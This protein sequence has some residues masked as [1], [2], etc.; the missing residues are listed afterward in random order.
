MQ[1]DEKDSGAGKLDATQ[2]DTPA[3]THSE[4]LLSSA[5]SSTTVPTMR[6]NPDLP[7]SNGG[8]EKTI[9]ACPDPSNS[10]HG[11]S[12]PEE[13]DPSGGLHQEEL[14]K[15]RHRSKLQ[16]VVLITIVTTGMI[17]NVSVHLLLFFSSFS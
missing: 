7:G 15:A 4:G 10:G 17:L 12:E 14:E 6:S 5:S 16:S 13:G 9:I 11:D 1:A 2:T 8:G 3:N